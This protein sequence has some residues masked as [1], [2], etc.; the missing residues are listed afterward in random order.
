MNRVMLRSRGSTRSNQDERKL[1]VELV[2]D[3]A[4]G[5]R[6]KGRQKPVLSNDMYSGCNEWTH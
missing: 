3:A 1:R 2:E 4:F 6:Q 5:L